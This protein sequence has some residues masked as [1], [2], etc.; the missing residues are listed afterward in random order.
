M[1][2]CEFGGCTL[3][4]VIPLAIRIEPDASA[5]V[6]WSRFA[7]EDLEVPLECTGGQ[8]C[9]PD[10]LCRRKL[11]ASAGSYEAHFRL[12]SWEALCETPEDCDCD[13]VEGTCEVPGL[14]TRF[15]GDP[16]IAPSVP[17][18]LPNEDVVAVVIE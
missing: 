9:D 18:E 3:E 5:T 16:D 1:S 8:L 11:L 7:Y 4:C 14:I 10:N 13:P 15:S 2:N 6:G 12:Y 17:F